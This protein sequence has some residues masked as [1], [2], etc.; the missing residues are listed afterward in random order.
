MTNEQIKQQL[1]KLACDYSVS[2]SD[3][4]LVITL[5]G[6]S[7]NMMPALRI[8][9]DLIDN[10]QADEEA[11]KSYVALVL[12]SRADNKANQEANFSALFD[13]GRYGEYNP[14]R[15]TVVSESTLKS[16]SAQTVLDYAKAIYT[17]MPNVLYYG[18]MTLADLCTQ[19][20]KMKFYTPGKVK[21]KMPRQVRPYKTQETS[22][23]EVY[24]A[25][26]DAKNV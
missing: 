5:Q 11:W 3:D 10:G 13:Y 19:I 4:E 7:E 16:M 20:D 23:N 21:F 17:Q 8:V 2:Q 15:N 26:Y 18:P 22:K 12:K 1:Y 9:K 6:L 24:I 14:N 25:P